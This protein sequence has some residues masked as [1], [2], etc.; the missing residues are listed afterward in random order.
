MLS[1]GVSGEQVHAFHGDS[2]VAVS[3]VGV[4]ALEEVIEHHDLALEGE[5]ERG[6]AEGEFVREGD[7]VIAGEGVR[8]LADDLLD[9][10]CRA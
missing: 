4:G 8:E 5:V 9:G 7:E 2:P 3:V 10:L 1:A 6:S